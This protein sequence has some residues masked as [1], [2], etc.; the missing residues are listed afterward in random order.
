[1]PPPPQSPAED[2]RLYFPATGRNREPILEVLRLVFAPPVHRVLE[3]ASGSG[4]HAVAF[5]AELPWITWHPT[6]VD[7]AHLASIDA[8]RAGTGLA[9]VAPAV[10]L[11][12][13]SDDWPEGPFDAV[14]CANMIHIAPW[15]ATLGLCAGAAR[16]LRPGG[17]MVTY[18]PYRRSGVPTA[19]SNEAFDASLRARDP[20]WGLR[21]VEE[22][23]AAAPGFSLE[24]IV[25]M[26]AN[27]LSLLWRR[28]GGA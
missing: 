10:R 20:R 9:R 12:V 22:L 19:L 15:E 7:P 8:W 26:P 1:M 2:G 17:V 16:A 24:R 23:A 21:S 3:I 14:F 27:N 5:A 4:E 18:G 13:L 28:S 11:D 6:D 25:E